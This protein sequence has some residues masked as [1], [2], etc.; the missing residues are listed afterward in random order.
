M[1]QPPV[2]PTD[3]LCSFLE[4]FSFDTYSKI[5]NLL[6]VL[7]DDD[8]DRQVPPFRRTR[9]Y[10]EATPW[11]PPEQRTDTSD[12]YNTMLYNKLVPILQKLFP[13]DFPTTY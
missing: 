4:G 13:V 9:I 7:S 2:S 10:P 8:L 1:E 12:F 3:S 5:Q 6:T 11:L